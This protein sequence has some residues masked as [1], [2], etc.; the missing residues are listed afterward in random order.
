MKKIITI[1][2]EENMIDMT[3]DYPIGFDINELKSIRSFNG[4]L[5]YVRQHL[6]KPIGT[7]SGREVYKVDDSK[8]LKMARNEKGVVQNKAEADW[9]GDTYFSILANVIDFDED[10]HIWLEMEIARKAKK[11]DFKRLWDVD[12]DTLYFYISNKYNENH[13]RKPSWEISKETEEK[14]DNNEYVAELVDLILST[15]VSYGDF[16]RVNSWGVVNRDGEETLVII[17]MGLT[18]EIHKKYYNKRR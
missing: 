2:K 17:D 7:G 4:K 5:T 16:G 13:G 14:Y 12:I 11:S 6:G 18:N 15:N 8:V 3:E 9:Y 1:L 10:N